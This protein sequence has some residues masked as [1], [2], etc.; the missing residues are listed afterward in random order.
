MPNIKR[1][2]MGAAGAGGDAA[3]MFAWGKN[4]SGML[5]LGDVLNRSSPVQVGDLVDWSNAAGGE[6]YNIFLK[7]DGTV[8]GT[9]DGGNGRN[10]SETKTT[11]SSPVQMTN[12]SGDWIK[13]S[14]MESFSQLIKDDGTL[15]NVGG[16]T[17]NRGS[18]GDGTTVVKSSP[19][20]LGVGKTFKE[21]A[22]GTWHGVAIT[23]SGQAWSWGYNTYGQLGQG[24]A[25]D[26]PTPGLSSIVQMGSASNWTKVACG[27][28]STALVNSSGELWF[29]GQNASGVGGLNNET[30]VSSLTQEAGGRTDWADVRI[31][32]AYNSVA[33]TPGGTIFSCGNGGDGAGGRSN[34][35]N[36][37]VFTQIG[38]LTTW[39][40]IGA[41][42]NWTVGAT[43]TDGTLWLWGKATDGSLGDGQ[44]AAARSSPVQLGSD[45]GWAT[46]TSNW[47]PMFGVKGY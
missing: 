43:K 20:Q 28:A 34:T 40:S 25:S 27:P 17:G 36:V 15:W 9:G 42:R 11:Y 16:A 14:C 30:N 39:A 33:L 12:D 23:E 5:G 29:C 4:S 47:F 1:G 22:G 46:L 18:V 35:T 38:S 21:V 26:R 31:G 3:S 10:L 19:I 24:S 6:N 8:W 13:I 37:S 2:M 45:T 44:A 32:S 7:T 41:N